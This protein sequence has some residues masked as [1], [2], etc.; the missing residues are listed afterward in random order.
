MTVHVQEAS[1]VYAPLLANIHTQCFGAGAQW[2]EA[3]IIALLSSP[4][5]QAGLVMVKDQPAGFIML[6]SVVD[7]AEVLTICILPENRKRGLAQRL[8]AWCIQVGQHNGMQNLFL[9]VSV[10]NQSARALYE[11]QGF[12]KL[13]LRKKYYEDGSDALV[14]GRSCQAVSP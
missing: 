10:N 3:A 2:D 12:E 8:L 14:L 13:G 9:E 4:G 11:K 7:E 6:R 1:V 5:V